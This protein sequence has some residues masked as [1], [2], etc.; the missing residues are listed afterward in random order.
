[1]EIIEA[2]DAT[3]CAHGAQLAGADA[4]TVSR[5]AA[6]GDLGRPVAG[7]GR[8]PRLIDLFLDKIEEKVKRSESKALAAMSGPPG[9][10]WR[11]RRPAGGPGTGVPTGRDHRAGE[12]SHRGQRDSAEATTFSSSLAV[13]GSKRY[14]S[15]TASAF[16]MS[17]SAESLVSELPSHSQSAA[18]SSPV[19][20]VIRICASIPPTRPLAASKTVPAGRRI[21]GG[22]GS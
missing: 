4:K 17:A 9:G 22:S 20:P 21:L 15:A 16:A 5:Y 13:R 12:G 10:R 6:A 8:R 14:G 1:M 2:N 18:S 19:P 11:K 7:S 3:G